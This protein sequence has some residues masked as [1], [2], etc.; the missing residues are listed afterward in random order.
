MTSVSSSASPVRSTVGKQGTRCRGGVARRQL[1]EHRLALRVLVGEAQAAVLAS[2]LQVD[3]AHV[4][5]QRDRQPRD[6]LEGLLD[7]GRRAHRVRG[8]REETV[9]AL[10]EAPV[11]DVEAGADDAR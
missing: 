11:V 7:V 10:D 1:A 4:G 6:L 3:E 2:V 9:A 8:L 5:Q